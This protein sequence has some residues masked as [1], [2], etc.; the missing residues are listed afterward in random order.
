[1]G[2]SEPKLK[3]L[4]VWTFL[5]L[6]NS[7]PR[8]GRAAL[9][10][11]WGCSAGPPVVCIVSATPAVPDFALKRQEMVMYL[12]CAGAPRPGECSPLHTLSSRAQNLSPM[13][14]AKASPVGHNVPSPLN[15][16]NTYI[17][18]TKLSP[19]H[20]KIKTKDPGLKGN[21]IQIRK[22]FDGLKMH[23]LKT[24]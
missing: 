15:C 10:S 4:R 1:M 16:T 23:L 13:Q 12:L 2:A 24:K 17:N 19:M 20:R 6:P 3:R 18:I 8:C 21:L 7:P 22:K 5:S 14:P 9:P 11:G